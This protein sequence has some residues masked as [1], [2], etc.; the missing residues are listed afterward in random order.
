MQNSTISPLGPKH[1]KLKVVKAGVALICLALGT[2]V[3]SV[4]AAQLPDFT[5][6]VKNNE[7]AVVNISTTSEPKR[8]PSS[9]GRPGGNDRLEEFYKFFG[10]PSGPNAVSY[11]HLTLP[12]TD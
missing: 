11:T 2:L 5:S 3:S 8:R 7:A 6:L 4:S 10:P 1:S 9:P 12:T